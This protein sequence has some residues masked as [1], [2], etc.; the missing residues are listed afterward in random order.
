M[1]LRLKY[2]GEV[3]PDNQFYIVHPAEVGLRFAGLASKIT[4][5]SS[6]NNY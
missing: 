6:S 1:R 4:K 3:V 2:R 5:P